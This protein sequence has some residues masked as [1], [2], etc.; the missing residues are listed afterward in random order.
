MSKHTAHLNPLET[1]EQVGR[2]TFD[3]LFGELGEQAAKPAKAPAPSSTPE[4]QPSNAQ[5]SNT[6]D[7]D[8]VSL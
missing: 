6:V 7:T 8:G 3:L 1:V 2:L 5:H 4:P